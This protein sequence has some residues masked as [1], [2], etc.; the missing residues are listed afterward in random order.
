MSRTCR[1]FR[2]EAQKRLY[3][4]VTLE[5]DFLSKEGRYS[6]ADESGKIRSLLRLPFGIRSLK[7]IA[8]QTCAHS[9]AMRDRPNTRA[10]VGSQQVALAFYMA[11][12]RHKCNITS[13]TFQ[14]TDR[15]W[16]LALME[17]LAKSE[18]SP[19][20]L[21]LEACASQAFQASE[22]E[23]LLVQW[24]S[25][26]TLDME[27]F[28]DY[29]HLY[30]DDNDNYYYSYSNYLVDGGFATPLIPSSGAS[31]FFQAKQ[32]QLAELV[33]HSLW[34][35]GNVPPTAFYRHMR[36]LHVG[37]SC[38][39]SVFRL[40]QITPREEVM[41]EK[42][43]MWKDTE[44]EEDQGLVWL[45]EKKRLES[46]SRI[47]ALLGLCPRLRRARLE[48]TKYD[49]AEFEFMQPPN[50][51]EH[52]EIVYTSTRL[53]IRPF[54]RLIHWICDRTASPALQSMQIYHG[55][56]RQEDA[57]RNCSHVDHVGEFYFSEDWFWDNID[58]DD[59]CLRT[60]YFWDPDSA[61]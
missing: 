57:I 2:L 12:M 39:R 29:G 23:S 3:R 54:E 47:I 48:L 61:V 53:H 11:E 59:L 55:W 9:H 18:H 24:P 10:I 42:L 25:C 50:S 14:F 13:F 58:D 49:M 32:P 8:E 35:W 45:S 40:L 19:T 15:I 41:I 26:S 38:S 27:P 51:I 21:K 52:L 1:A 7:L 28:A 46:S 36:A 33:L 31:A 22:L 43:E 60:R 20:R 34:L 56:A 6:V 30:D 17:A 37:S 44:E 4:S 16:V 5:F